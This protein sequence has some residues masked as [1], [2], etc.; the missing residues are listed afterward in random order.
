MRVPIKIRIPE[1]TLPNG[2]T[3]ELDMYGDEGVSIKQ[4][5]KDMKDPKK[6]FTDYS[7]AFTVPAS[8]KNNAIFKHYY[9]VEI[10]D[11]FDSREL[12]PA[13]IL[14]GN[15][16]YK[17][18]NIS[19]EGVKMSNGVPRSYKIRF[20]GKLSELARRIG[21]D[22]ISNLDFS[23]FDLES[24]NPKNEF[25]T[26][27]AN[28]LVFPLASRSRRFIVDSSDAQAANTLNLENAK[29]IRYVGTNAYGNIY[30]LN[31]RDLVGALK[32]GTILDA[33]ETKYGIN[34]QGVFTRDYV[35]FLYL[36]LHGGKQDK[37][38][39]DYY[40]YSGQ[41]FTPL[42]AP[43]NSGGRITINSSNID[44]S[45]TPSGYNYAIQ[46]QGTWTG[47]G[48]AVLYRDGQEVG[49]TTSSSSL[50]NP[51]WVAHQEGSGDPAVGTGTYTAKLFTATSQTGATLKIRVAEYEETIQQGEIYEELVF[52]SNYDYTETGISIGSNV[53][54]FISENIPEIK[55]MDFLAILFQM[56]NIISEVDENLN[57]QTRH[58]DAYMSE[59][60]LYDVTQFVNQTDYEVKKPNLYSAIS[61]KWADA[62]TALEQG[63][64]TVNGKQ[65]GSLDY[66]ITGADGFRLSGNEYVLDVKSQRIPVERLSNLFDDSLTRIAYTSFADLKGAEQSHKPAFTYIA[67]KTGATGLAWTDFSTTSQV[68]NYAQP[69]SVF[70][71]NTEA[72][73][74]LDGDLGLFF[75]E[76]KNEQQLDT[77]VVGFGLFNNFYRG[78]TAMIFDDNT[79]S[80]KFKAQLPNRIL[81][82]LKM[83]DTLY[84]SG[85]F[86]M[87]NSIETNYLTGESKLDLTLTGRAKLP[88]FE[89]NTWS[90]YNSGLS[91]LRV[92][93]VNW[94][95]FI[96]EQTISPKSTANVEAVGY[97][98]TFSNPNYTASLT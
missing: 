62:K 14:M 69:V 97:I 44:V 3:P 36:W 65:Y 96:D 59:G 16:T 57:V 39:T 12:V 58:H 24:F 92:T 95:G 6:L 55:V 88:Y 34:F 51:V 37:V 67:S 22:K 80:V 48:Y 40:Q 30:G 35:R 25:T 90:V 28:D 27:A 75:G 8:K 54:Y 31:E 42:T 17:I 79:R 9:N 46:V 43:A 45:G 23:A 76:E 93:F 71:G 2:Q 84:I 94:N 85:K 41:G 74:V 21:Q 77:Q 19:L 72:T 56:F 83:S 4:V 64:E 52:L 18:G 50:S 38:G 61:Y 78:L 5:V 87:I 91:S 73:T 29:N 11:G 20:I 15:A 81:L 82:N 86:Y 53:S 47:A 68:T 89:K 26:P 10:Q 7:R 66:E 98:S 63:Y 70:N 32:V 33:I 60:V 13:E 1:A 49:R